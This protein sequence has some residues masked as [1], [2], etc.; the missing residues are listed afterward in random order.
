VVFV[1]GIL[2]ILNKLL[3]YNIDLFTSAGNEPPKAS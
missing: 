3:N 1:E 2:T